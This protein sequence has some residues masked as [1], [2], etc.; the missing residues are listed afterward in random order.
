MKPLERLDE[1]K[2]IFLRQ[3]SDNPKYE[4]L[5]DEKDT[6]V[7]DSNLGEINLFMHYKREGLNSG[8]NHENCL[9]HKIH[10]KLYN[11]ENIANI[12]YG[13]GQVF[14]SGAK[15]YVFSNRKNHAKIRLHQKEMFA[16]DL[17]Q[18]T[19]TETERLAFENNVVHGQFP[20]QHPADS[21]TYIIPKELGEDLRIYTLT[22]VLLRY[23]N[24]TPESKIY[25]F[26][27]EKF[28]KEKTLA[29]P[30]APTKNSF[31]L[32]PLKKG[33]RVL[34]FRPC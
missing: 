29:K 22:P 32:V 27:N 14:F 34:V 10:Q 31:E 2:E 12:F 20:P 9:S 25:D 13:D 6:L 1:M 28:A 3:L 7:L 16:L 19:K 5:R 18:R 33:G 30:I 4:L 24:I 11:H 8:V 23:P 21:L 26:V 15:N 17:Q